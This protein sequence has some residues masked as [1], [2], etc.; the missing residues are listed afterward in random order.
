ML[1]IPY[2]LRIDQ[3]EGWANSSMFRYQKLAALKL[4]ERSLH[5]IQQIFLDGDS[6]NNSQ[7]HGNWL[8]LTNF[9]K[10]EGRQLG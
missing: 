5:K 4:H 1:H 8:H 7:M 6:E 9:S 2:L 10:D 3:Y